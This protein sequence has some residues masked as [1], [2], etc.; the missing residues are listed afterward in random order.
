MGA[1]PGFLYGMTLMLL[2]GLGTAPA[3]LIVG[4]LANTN[5]VKSKILIERIGAVLM[6]LIGVYFTYQGLRF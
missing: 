3:M 4:G 2:F 6:I 5:W 1:G